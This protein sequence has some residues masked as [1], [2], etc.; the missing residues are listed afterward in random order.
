MT[1]AALRASIGCNKE[2]IVPDLIRCLNACCVFNERDWDDEDG[3]GR[4]CTMA[5]EG[6]KP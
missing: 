2:M 6:E 3:C 4:Y 5:D 1:A